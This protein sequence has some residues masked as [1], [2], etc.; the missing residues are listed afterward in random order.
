MRHACPPLLSAPLLCLRKQGGRF[1]PATSRSSSRRR[2][3]PSAESV[4]SSRAT[5]HDPGAEHPRSPWRWPASSSQDDAT[6]AAL[7][8][9]TRR[10]LAGQARRPASSTTST[11]SAATTSGC[12][13]SRDGLGR[14][15]PSSRP[16]CLSII[17]LSPPPTAR[18]RADGSI[19]TTTSSLALITVF[20]LIPDAAATAVLPPR[21]N[22]SAVAPATTRRCSSFICG[23]TTVKNRSSP[24]GV[25]S[26]PSHYYA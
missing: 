17:G 7:C 22:I 1:Q 21:P 2:P 25:I 14:R 13:G 4:C 20:R 5:R 10:S 12:R 23:N 15:A 18:R 6:C 24:S 19:P 8:V 26:T 9:R 16:G 3:H 11:S